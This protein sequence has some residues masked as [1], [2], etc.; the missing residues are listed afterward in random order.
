MKNL[1]EKKIRNTLN[2]LAGE[3]ELARKAYFLDNSPVLSDSEFDSLV[4]R[5]EK[6]KKEYPNLVPNDDPSTRI[7]HTGSSTFE[8]VKHNIPLLSLSNAF[9]QVDVIRFDESIKRFLG[10]E[11]S[12]SVKYMAEP[13]IDG[14]SL[15]LKYRNGR[16]VTAATRGDGKIGEDVTH[17]A[18]TIND[19]P[20]RIINAPDF[21]E[22]R[23]EVYILKSD[24]IKLNEFQETKGQK[25]FA[26]ARNAAAGSLRQMDSKV[27]EKRPLRFFAYSLEGMGYSLVPSQEKLMSILSNF[28]FMINHHSKICNGVSELIE[29]YEKIS[30]RR[31][32]LDYEIDGVV[33][34]VN[35]F[36]YQERLGA[37]TNSPRWAI[38]H[39]FVPE[40]CFTKLLSIEIQVGRT[41]TL[42][43]VA[44]LEPVEIGGVVVSS[45]TLHNEDF[46]KGYDNSGKIIRNGIDIRIGDLVSVYRAGDVIP[47]IKSINLAE[48]TNASKPFLFP[49]NCPT[50]GSKVVKLQNES[51]TRCHAG[52]SC[53]AQVV[54]RLKHFASKSCCHIEGFGEKQ[55]LNFYNLGWVTTPVDI[56]RLESNHGRYSSKPLEKLENWGRKSAE[57]L[58]ASINNSRNLSLERFI[59]AL[60]IR[61]VGEGVSLI[62]ARYYETWVQFNKKMLKIAEGRVAEFDELNNIDGIGLKSAE[63]LKLYFSKSENQ[64]LVELLSLEI[65]VLRLISKNVSGP[66]SGLTIVFT[67]S[68]ESM[69]R[70][71]A[72]SSAE[73]MG[74]KVS[75]TISSKTDMLVCGRAAGSK[76]T[77]AKEIGV[78]ILTEG[79]WIDYVNDKGHR[80]V[81]E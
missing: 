23:G 64:K 65:N 4:K 9:N 11:L 29:A 73:K 37:R 38:A 61:Y 21:V 35:N 80:L 41:G 43:P 17:N 62:L 47:K 24:F 27:T 12:T 16:L 63:E 40:E 30:K 50:C 76:V 71:E 53:S 45:A 49:L 75:N 66:I 1:D 72:K 78:K 22:V 70:S 46:I 10:I 28:G 68:L 52:L 19:I 69:S 58:F 42:S 34:K 36:N 77:K 79:E 31:E 51:V 56:F 60:G 44:K 74:A 25:P 81:Q 59:N 48:R 13:K 6:I 3:I 2:S 8:K 26:N 67:G 20:K 39:K 5:F 14:L 15:A 18:L 55:I 33:Y 7:G 57:K 32:T 54:E